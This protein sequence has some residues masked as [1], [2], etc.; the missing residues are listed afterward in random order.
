M[1][2]FVV[3][4]IK[5]VRCKKCGT[6]YLPEKVKENGKYENCPTCGFCHN[7]HKCHIPLWWYKLIRYKRQK[8]NL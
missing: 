8:L 5:M 3:P 1:A 4:L 7:D 2:K 6:V